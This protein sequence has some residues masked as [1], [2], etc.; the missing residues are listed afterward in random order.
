MWDDNAL[1]KRTFAPA[2]YAR[3]TAIDIGR[4]VETSDMTDHFIQFMETDQ[5]GRI[6]VNHRILADQEPS[7]TLHIDC[8]TLAEMHS[9]AV[10]FSKTGI[11][12]SLL[13]SC[14]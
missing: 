2:D 12:V 11:P 10:D 7:G 14:L 13:S 4:T 8:I 6:A 1:P 9:T 5:L 3:P